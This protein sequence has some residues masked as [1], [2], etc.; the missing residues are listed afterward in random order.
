[1]T[2]P[3]EW[4]CFHCGDV[5]TDPHAAAQHFGIDEG[6]NTACKIKGSEHGL[7]K[8]LRDAEAEADEAIQRMHSESTDAAKAYHRQRTRHVQALIAAEE[9]GYARGM[10]DARAELAQPLLKALEKIA[11]KDTDGLHMLT[12]QA[13]QAIARNAVHAHTSNFGEQINVQA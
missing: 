7:I 8:A 3:L 13:M 11:E 5:F 6:K 4:R 10:R 2:A 12:P 9:V 1:M